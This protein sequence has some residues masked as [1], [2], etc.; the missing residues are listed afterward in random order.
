[1]TVQ[2]S[3][4]INAGQFLD[5]I[6]RVKLYVDVSTGATAEQHAN[7]FRGKSLGA[8][9]A[10][11]QYAAIAAGTFDNLYIGDYWTIGNVN[12]RIAD[13]DYWFGKGFDEICST[14][15][16]VIVPDSGL[17]SAKMNDTDTTEYGYH[18]SKMRTEKL[19]QAKQIINSAFGPE[20][21][22]TKQLSFVSYV[23]DGIPV[24]STG[25]QST[26]DLMNEINVYGYRYY[27]PG[28]DGSATLVDNTFDYSQFALFRLAPKFIN[29]GFNNAWWLRDVVSGSEF[30]AFGHFGYPAASSASSSLLVRP[31]FAICAQEG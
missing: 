16:A 15:H 29:I 26:V 5:G 28:N 3:D 9:V 18:R 27:A 4:Y 24:S 11:E 20:H 17:Y 25:A 12:W 8:T 22:L 31:A 7:V 30:A 6:H 1:M 14:H 2:D 23:E 21:I 19:E 10:N 13:F